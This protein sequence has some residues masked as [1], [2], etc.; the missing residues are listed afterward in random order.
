MSMSMIDRVLSAAKE[1]AVHGESG[2]AANEEFVL[3]HVDGIEASGFTAHYKLPH[4]V[5]FQADMSVLERTQNYQKEQF[6]HT[7]EKRQQAADRLQSILE[8]AIEN[9]PV[10][11]DER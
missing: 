10:T 3:M 8:H 7:L 4:Y 1:S 11:N 9:P 2:P 6:A 5:S